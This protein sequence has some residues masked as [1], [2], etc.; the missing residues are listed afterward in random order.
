GTQVG[1]YVAATYSFD[2][3]AHA[4]NRVQPYDWNKFLRDRLEGHASGAPL[5]GLTRGGYKLVYSDKPSEYFR[6]SEERRRITD[7]TYSLGMVIGNEG[8][9]TDVL[10]E[11]LAYQ[12]SVTVGTQIVA[13]DGT[14]YRAD[15]LKDAIREAARSGASIELLVKNGDRYRTVRFDYHDGLRYPRLERIAGSPARLDDIF[16]AKK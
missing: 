4:L 2:D 16:T 8:R 1:S 15:H 12:K 13:V 11:G 10:W 7:L 9:L 14:S 6:N 3:V 5:D